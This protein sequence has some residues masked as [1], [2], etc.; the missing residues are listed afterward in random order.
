M[1]MTRKH[2]E[3]IAAAVADSQAFTSGEAE[4]QRFR[5]ADSLAD[6]CAAENSMFDRGRFLAACNVPEESER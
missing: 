1:A 2:F 4:A 5:V 3:A 6:F